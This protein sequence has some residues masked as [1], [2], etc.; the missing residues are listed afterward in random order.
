MQP[1][2]P[3]DRLAQAGR[4]QTSRVGGQ[5][6][7]AEV[8]PLSADRH[9]H[10]GA[11]LITLEKRWSHHA[12]AAGYNRLGD[13]LGGQ[14]VSRLPLTGSVGQ[15]VSKAWN[16]LHGQ[17]AHLFD[18]GLGDRL[19]EE[20]AFW[21][22][23]ATRPHIIHALYG[24]EQLDLLLRRA[25]LLGSRL[26]ATFHLPSERTCERF[27]HLQRHELS[28]LAGAIVVASYEV[29]TFA[30]WLGPDKVL[31][32]PHG[33]DTEAFVAGPGNRGDALRLVFVGLHM[34]DFEVAHRVIDRCAANGVNADFDIVLPAQRWSYFTGCERVRRH[35]ELSDDALVELYRCADALFLP[36]TGATANNAVLEALACGTPVI[37]TRVGGMPDYVDDTCGWL[38]P[39]GDADAAYDCVQR[40][41]ADRSAARALRAGA[42]MRAEQLSW[43]HVAE[44]VQAAY[45]RLRAGRA[46]AG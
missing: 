17:P 4:L 19:A 26:V 40:L 43:P 24:D 16:W 23:L 6:G 13:Y 42:R 44:Q 41:A 25:P 8:D 12:R 32:V 5:A 21:L 22:A 31:Y 30:Q 39:P 46:F 2:P 15:L 18:Y 1:S 33:I 10:D 37:S 28:H 38:L 27:E 45:A 3:H 29:P 20:R 36:V 35:S 7:Q 34:R 9:A 11:A 14:R